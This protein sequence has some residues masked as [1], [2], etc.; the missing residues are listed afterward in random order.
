MMSIRQSASGGPVRLLV[1]A[2]RDFPMKIRGLKMGLYLVV[3]LGQSFSRSGS[4][5]MFGG[6]ASLTGHVS[7][8]DSP[9]FF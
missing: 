1:G 2:N 7:C 8:C 4:S 3:Q 9:Y 5:A 6:I